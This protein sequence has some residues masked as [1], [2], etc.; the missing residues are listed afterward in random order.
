VEE[1]PERGE[2][3][4]WMEDIQKTQSSKSTVSLHIGIHID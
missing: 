4:E 3:P 1:E 2:K